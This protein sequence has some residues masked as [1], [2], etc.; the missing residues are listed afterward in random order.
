MGLNARQKEAVEYLDGP[1]LVLA[2][3]GTGKTQLLSEKVAYILKNTDTN[4]E[5]ILC[6]TF[7]ETGASNMRERL[8]SIVGRDGLK[9]NIGTYHAFGQDILAQYRNYAENYDRKLDNSIDE[10]QQFKIVKEIR[11]GLSGT[12]ILRGDN[13]KDIIAVIS[14]AKAAGLSAEDLRIIAERNMA[15]SE[16]LSSAISPL[17][18]NVVPRNFTASFS[19]AY[20]PIH[21]ILKDYEETDPILKNIERSISGLARD[22]KEAISVASETSKIKPLTEWKDKY[23]EKDEKGN[24]RLRDRVANKKLLSISTVMSRY[25]EY[26]KEA[27]LFDFDDMIQ[28]A[29]R[30]LEEDLGFRATLSERYQFIMLDEFQ[31][32]NPSQFKIVKLLTDYEKPAIMAVGDDDQAIYEFQGALATNLKDFQEHYGAKVVALEENYRSTQEILDFSREIIRQAPDRFVKDKKLFAH[33]KS[34][35]ASQIERREFLSSEAEYGFI[36]KQISELVRAGVPQSLIAV[37]SYKTKYFMPLLSHLKDY[38]EI[39]IAYDKRDNLLEDEKIHQILTILSFVYEIMN[40]TR[41]DTPILEILTYPFFGLSTVEVLKAMRVMRSE[42]CSAIE[43]LLMAENDEIRGVAEFLM[44]LV[45]RAAVEPLEV[46]FGLLIEKMKPDE[47]A[48][49]ERFTFYENLAA[50]VGK[51]RRHFGERTLYLKDLILM[52]RDYEEA[53]M[54]LATVS[55]YR[56]ADEAVQILTAHK[57]KGLEFEYVFMISVDHVA[58]GKGKG[59]NNLLSLPKNLTQIRHT[60]TTDGEKL[61]IL[62]VAMTRA[63]S[64][65]I[66]TNS[67]HDFNGKAP[68]RLEYLEESVQKDPETGVETVVSPF[69]PARKVILDYE[70]SASGITGENGLGEGLTG[71]ENEESASGIAGKQGLIRNLENWLTPFIAT[72][73]DMRAIYKERVRNYRM[74]AT[75]LTSFIDIIYAGPQEFFKREILKSPW[76]PENEALILG[77]LIHKV[78][79]AVTNQGIS[80]EEATELFS[81]ELDEKKIEAEA[82]RRVREK[83]E[84]SLRASL[85]DFG[86]IL[87]SGK[88]E[89]NFERENLTAREVPI[90]GRLDHIVIDEDAKTIEI[91][92]FKTSSYRKEKWQSQA[93]LYKYMLQ[94]GFYKLLLNSSALYKNYTVTR[95]HILFVSPDNDGEVHDK[96][97]EFNDTDEKELIDLIRAVYDQ[98]V[99][100]KFMDDAEVFVRAD[101]NLGLKDMKNF[102]ALLLAKNAD[103]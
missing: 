72:A 74:S 60:G 13:V 67:L 68:D 43:A 100:L 2:G 38:P 96:V 92:D 16:V 97:Y 40:E 14:D 63:K 5:N 99:S 15:D 87:R 95:G 35:A 102:I 28:E 26:L 49:Y 69:L 22:L 23:F 10:V 91:Y 73:P 25:Q 7:T 19:G 65:L 51:V 45:R 1:L 46:I 27:G 103:N 94:L 79:E 76:E 20:Q 78:F 17:L 80:D 85:R 47:L 89:V 66:L 57:A 44:E 6:L 83:G 86:A 24:Y 21:E 12:D 31:D 39:K 101:Q 90:L 36:A 52:V 64:H 58:W 8:K 3:P 59:N 32:T 75:G 37:I 55:P 29:I 11:G 77:N 41:V 30:A 93:T 84:A 33:K 88:A 62:Y 34:P 53:E 4:P 61:R 98:I 18:L 71:V 82:C 81:K 9:V 48:E 56:D 50:L 70:E 54:M 42:K